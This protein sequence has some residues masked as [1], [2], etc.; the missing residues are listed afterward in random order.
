MMPRRFISQPSEYIDSGSDRDDLTAIDELET[1]RVCDPCVPDPNYGPPP[2]AARLFMPMPNPLN[3]ANRHFLP[4]QSGSSYSTMP[5]AISSGSGGAQSRRGTMPS[6]PA[7]I[8]D[9]GP[10]PPNRS[11]S[12]SQ[13][14][15]PS[16]RP[17][18][19]SPQDFLA[20]QMNGMRPPQQQRPPSPPQPRVYPN[21]AVYKA[22][23]KDAKAVNDD[24]DPPECVICLCE[25]EVGEDL[26]L[27]ECF[28]KFH[29]ECIIGWWDKD[30]TASCPTHKLRED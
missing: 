17:P 3:P 26:A 21:M 29:K 27:L 5:Q 23:E 30:G 22:S 28:C 25:F 14:H 24:E 12:L 19:A 10:P 18:F 16:T 11:A 8:F 4:P 1:V 20:W 7:G 9:I 2:G 15:Q 6:Y 13:S